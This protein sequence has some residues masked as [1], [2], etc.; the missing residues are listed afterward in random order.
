MRG[1]K[2]SNGSHKVLMSQIVMGGDHISQPEKRRFITRCFDRYLE[3]GGNCF[4]TARI[5]D[6]GE[7]E[8][9]LGAYLKGKPRGS[10]VICTKCGHHDR[11]KPPK[12]KLSREEISSDINTS[13]KAL[14]CEYTDILFLH[15]DDIYK[16]VEEIMP[17]L[18]EIV[19]A[20]KAVL[21]GASNWT[22]GRIAAANIFA[23]E[24]GLTPFSVSQVLYNLGLTTAAQ[25]GDLTHLC[26]DN[27]ELCWYIENQ[28]PVMAWTATGKGFFAKAA[29]GLPMKQNAAQYYAWLPENFKRAARAKKLSE[30]LGV[31]VSA[32]ILAY[33]LNSPFPCAGVTAFSND[34][35]F[36]ETMQAA[37]LVLTA[38][39]RGFLENGG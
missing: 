26:M 17:I 27:S 11:G 18:H 7:A 21:L 10:Y 22:A 3:R 14:G 36:D 9:T 19:T 32:V 12:S 4:D 15:R 20:G 8:S 37:G 30:E 31:S 13:L 6:G 16:P 2:I 38:E 5:Y 33:V 35:Q 24:N 39:Q 29:A 25:T 1:V 34:G 23:R 28:L